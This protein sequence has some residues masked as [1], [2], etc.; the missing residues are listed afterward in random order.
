MQQIPKNRI[1]VRLG[2]HSSIF[3]ITVMRVSFYPTLTSSGWGTQDITLS[4]KVR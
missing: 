4:E 1:L 3:T 2:R